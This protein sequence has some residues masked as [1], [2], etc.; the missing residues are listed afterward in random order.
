MCTPYSILQTTVSRQQCRTETKTE[1][2]GS[3]TTVLAAEM[4]LPSVHDADRTDGDL[5]RVSMV[6]EVFGGAPSPVLDIDPLIWRD[7]LQLVIH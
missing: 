2:I 4:E 3:Y 7:D 6:V 5:L 1:L